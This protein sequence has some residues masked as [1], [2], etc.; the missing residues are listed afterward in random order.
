MTIKKAAPYMFLV[1]PKE[2]VSAQLLKDSAEKFY[3]V[4]IR[5]PD[6][7]RAFGSL[8]KEFLSFLAERFFATTYAR[9][10][11]AQSFG[12]KRK[13]RVNFLVNMVIPEN[14]EPEK[15]REVREMARLFS[16]PDRERFEAV[17]RNYLPQGVSFTFDELVEFART[18]A[19]PE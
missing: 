2:K 12:R 1:G 8:P 6:I 17:Q 10:L 16:R 5:T 11:R 14:A 13:D 19:I 4:L 15:L 3:D 9:V 7:N 18:G